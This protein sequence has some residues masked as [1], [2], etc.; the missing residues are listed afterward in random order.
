VRSA[1]GKEPGY[2]LRVARFASLGSSFGDFVV[3]VHDL[4]EGIGILALASWALRP[5]SRKLAP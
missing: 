3:H 4:P 2:M 1:I 5:E